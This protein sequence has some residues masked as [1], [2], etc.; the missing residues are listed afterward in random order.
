MSGNMI[1]PAAFPVTDIAPGRPAAPVPL[2]RGLRPAG[3]VTADRAAA[4]PQGGRKRKGVHPG[5]FQ[6]RRSSQTRRVSLA[7]TPQPA[8]AKATACDRVAVIARICCWLA[9]TGYL[10]ALSLEIVSLYAR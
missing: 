10:A 3:R 7:A 5:L 8:E 2:R 6:E 1:A 9:I 4:T